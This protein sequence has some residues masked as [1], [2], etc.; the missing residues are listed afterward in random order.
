M[1]R[2]E[3]LRRAAPGAGDA[4]DGSPG[5]LVTLAA[6][7]TPLP[8][9]LAGAPDLPGAMV[10]RSRTVEDGRERYRLHVGY[11]A[12]EALA[13][14]TLGRLRDAY[15]GAYVEPAPER[16]L[17]S[18]ED[19]GVAHF[20]LLY[21]GEP[22]AGAEPAPPAVAPAIAHVVPPASAPAPQQYVVQLAWAR[23]AI[24][25]ARLPRLP[26]FGS[27]FTYAVE[28][29]SGGRRWYGV[30]L[31]FFRDADSARLVARYI[32]GEY[33]DAR[34]LPVSDREVARASGASIR[35]Q[36]TPGD[37]AHVRWPSSAIP[38]GSPP[39]QGGGPR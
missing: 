33:R 35:L 19:T 18:L 6:S 9:V 30:R 23:E 31:G 32:R 16:G 26:I 2:K 29:D 8:L 24:D 4:D 17:G 7:D 28:T 27:Y 12:T 1:Y 25:C 34:V 22:P 21:W 10:F 37:A 38:V 11:F 15:P 14:V 3:S 20:R 36:A 5:W 13:A 39:P